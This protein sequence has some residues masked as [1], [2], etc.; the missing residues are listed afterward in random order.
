MKLTIDLTDEEAEKLLDMLGANDAG[1]CCEGWQSTEA[2]NLED[3]FRRAIKNSTAAKGSC[4]CKGF[5]TVAGC[6]VHAYYKE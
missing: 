3:K 4:I 5:F 6:P 2:K 1:S